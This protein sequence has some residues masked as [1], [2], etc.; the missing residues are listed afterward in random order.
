MVLGLAPTDKVAAAGDVPPTV[1]ENDSETGLTVSVRVAAVI[2]K[3]TGTLTVAPSP[4]R[5]LMA[6]LYLA[7][8]SFVGFTVIV[9]CCGV[10]RLPEGVTESQTRPPLVPDALTVKRA[11][12]EAVTVRVF[13]MAVVLPTDAVNDSEAGE[14][15]R[16][17]LPS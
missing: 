16:G 9:R 3:V 17:L 4:T 14:R 11:L 6:P 5:M 2:V 15:V 1:P 13:C 8:A 12:L 7:A 10:A